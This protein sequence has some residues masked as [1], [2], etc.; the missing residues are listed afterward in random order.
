VPASSPSMRLFRMFVISS[1][2]MC[3]WVGLPLFV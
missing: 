1:G 3:M 2:L